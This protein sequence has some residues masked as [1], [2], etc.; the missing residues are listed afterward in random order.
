MIP[1]QDVLPSR[2]TPR[3]TVGLMALVVVSQAYQLALSVPELRGLILAFGFTPAAWSVASVFA[4]LF[5][6]LGI[7]ETVANVWALWIFGD[8]VEDRL[9]AMRYLA[10]L[11][12]S[13]W[14]ALFVAASVDPTS[15]APLVGPA[16]LV[17]AAI[18][19]HL[20]L[21]PKSKVLVL[22][23]MWRGIDLVDVPALLIVAFWL[24]FQGLAQFGSLYPSPLTSTLIVPAA[25]AAC[26][27]V[28]VR[29]LRRPERMQATWWSP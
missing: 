2:T 23:P 27:A 21:F 26:G 8:N 20:S 22:V 24:L 5:I 4:T 29:I 3:V 11:L 17:A 10:L 16:G 7:V 18:G 9:G 25:A 1:V 13:A 6:H 28:G 19:A 15:R 14:T 12:V